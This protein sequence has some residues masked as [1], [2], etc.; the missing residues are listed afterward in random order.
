MHH[1]VCKRGNLCG[2]HWSQADQSRAGSNRTANVTTRKL[3]FYNACAEANFAQVQPKIMDKAA[4]CFHVTHHLLYTTGCKIHAHM[5]C[6][7]RRA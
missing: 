3:D 5:I 1:K 6:L 2:K 4:K 7:W